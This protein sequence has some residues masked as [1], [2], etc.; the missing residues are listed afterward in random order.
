VEIERAAAYYSVRQ[1]HRLES[2]KRR[3]DRVFARPQGSAKFFEELGVA[4]ERCSRLDFAAVEIN[5]DRSRT[6]KTQANNFFQQDWKNLFW[7]FGRNQP[8]RSGFAGGALVHYV[9]A[10]LS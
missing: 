1:Q 7:P 9:L 8:Q 5:L 6:R 2:G 4:V 3:D 10:S